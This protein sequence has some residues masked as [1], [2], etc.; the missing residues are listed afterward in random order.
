MM[1][2]PSAILFDKDGT[3]ID[4][5]R[6]WDR[7]TGEALR[8]VAPSESALRD[9]AATIGFDL[10]GDRIIPGS[11]M[12]AESNDV[13]IALLGPHLDTDRFVDSLFRASMGSICPAVG[14]DHLT[15][16]LFARGV[17]MAV[18]TN[19]WAEVVEHQLVALGWRDRFQAV[20]AAD[21][22]HGA[23]PDPG[24]VLAGLQALDVSG[25]DVLMVGDSSHDLRAGSSAGVS[26][27]LVTNGVEPDAS[28]ADLAGLVV[29]SLAELAVLMGLA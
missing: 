15:A 24:M 18:V 7:A 13:L 3:L 19:D 9:A 2:L 21:S 17:P 12:V 6:T 1:E 27:V 14:A 4:F 5:H 23:K 25:G 10:R 8:E 16:S 22:G 11:P 29:A 20:L 26:T 28:V